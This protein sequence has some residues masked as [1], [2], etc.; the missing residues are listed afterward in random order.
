M[1][2]L[3]TISLLALAACG[4]SD[5]GITPPPKK[6]DPYVTIRVRDVMDTTTAAGRAHWHSY[7][8]LTGPY[9]ALNGIFLESDFSL[10]DRRL[11]HN[12]QCLSISADSVGQRLLSVVAFADTTTEQSTASAQFDDYSQ[13]WYSGNH[14]LPTGWMA[15]TFAPVDAWQSAQY[16][17]GHGLRPSDPVKWDLTWT[18]AGVVSFTERTDSDAQC[19]TAF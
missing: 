7:L 2:H 6:P 10:T 15:L 3:L 11:N 4:G 12:V 13:V 16:L 19:S 14:T 1:R 8:M 5:H 17:A 9:T 18:G